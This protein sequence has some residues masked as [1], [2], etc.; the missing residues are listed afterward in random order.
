VKEREGRWNVGTGSDFTYDLV[1]LH[2]PRHQIVTMNV[3]GTGPTNITQNAA[4]DGT[5]AWSP[6]GRQLAFSTNRDA[7]IEIYVMNADGTGQS[8]LT[9]RAGDDRV[10]DWTTRKK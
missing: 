7:N 6:D 9:Q 1:S 4:F 10:P 3:D 5:A 2:W 8:N